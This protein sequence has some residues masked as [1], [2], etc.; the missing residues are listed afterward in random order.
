MEILCSAAKVDFL[1]FP[2]CGTREKAS[3]FNVSAATTLD[4]AWTGIA[5]SQMLFKADYEKN[6]ACFVKYSLSQSL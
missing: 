2:F 3:L 6:P 1:G 4:V 5:S